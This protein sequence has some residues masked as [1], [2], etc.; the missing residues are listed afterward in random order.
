[1]LKLGLYI[2][3]IPL[4]MMITTRIRIE[5]IFRKNS[6]I[7]IKLFYVFISLIMSYLLVNFLMDFK[8]A[9]NIL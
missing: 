9:A 5:P 6:E 7:Q 2:I 1:M 8:V 3:F 4:C